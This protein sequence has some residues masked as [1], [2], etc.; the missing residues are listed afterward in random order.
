MPIDSIMITVIV[1][2]YNRCESLRRT[3]NSLA[4]LSAADVSWELVVVDNHS[5]DDTAE[6]VRRFV[7]NSTFAIRY[8]F[9]INQGLSYA[10]NAGIRAARG[11]IIAFTD[12]DVVVDSNWLC[13]LQRT[14]DQF[15][16]FECIT[17][18]G[19]IF[20]LWT[21]EKSSWLELNGPNPFQSG[22]IISFDPWFD[23][24]V[25]S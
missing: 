15:D 23:E 1:C 5:K 18:G 22:T 20:A 4:Q 12:D 10:R 24:L 2:T 6:V 7:E 21:C 25:A 16:Q 13:E 9:E 17:V 8:V 3:L 19:R 11:E 14:F